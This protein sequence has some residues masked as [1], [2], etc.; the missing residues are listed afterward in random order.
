[1]R[2]QLLLP[3]LLLFSISIGNSISSILQSKVQLL[4]ENLT[5]TLAMAAG[6][7]PGEAEMSGS[8]CQRKFRHLFWHRE[9]I[10]DLIWEATRCVELLSNVDAIKKKPK[11]SPLGII[12]STVQQ[13]LH[14]TGRLYTA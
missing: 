10:I 2:F 9:F 11:K 7:G 8:L 6:N 14:H 1:M 3:F 13:H 12:V 4:G 5:A